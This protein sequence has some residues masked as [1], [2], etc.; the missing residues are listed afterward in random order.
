LSETFAQ[1]GVPKR[2]LELAAQ[3]ERPQIPGPD[4]EDLLRL[5]G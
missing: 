4:R 1:D 2:I 3:H 5:L